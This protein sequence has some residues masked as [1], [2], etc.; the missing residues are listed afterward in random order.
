MRRRRRRPVPSTRWTCVCVP[1]RCSKEVDPQQR[2]FGFGRAVEDGARAFDHVVVVRVGA[3][4]PHLDVSR[5]L[6][7]PV[8]LQV[9]PGI[10]EAGGVAVD[11]ETVGATREGTGPKT[12]VRIPH[13]A[14]RKTVSSGV[15]CVATMVSRPFGVVVRE[16]DVQILF[17]RPGVRPQ[18]VGARSADGTHPLVDDHRYG[19]LR[20]LGAKFI[21][22]R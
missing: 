2:R 19:H 11:L 7:D 13:L 6:V 4:S 22:R 15:S 21:S 3:S 17:G 12:M 1:D 9:A 5:A 18:Q 8:A 14:R 20:T 10:W 16:D